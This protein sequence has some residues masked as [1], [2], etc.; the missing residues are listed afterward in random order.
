M[1][2]S[3]I[4]TIIELGQ[5]FSK[6]GNLLYSEEEVDYSPLIR[7]GGEKES[8]EFESWEKIERGV[9]ILGELKAPEISF[10]CEKLEEKESLYS[11]MLSEEH[12]ER[13]VKKIS[14]GKSDIVFSRE[15]VN[16]PE[17][18]LHR[19]YYSRLIE[20][21]IA[22][23]NPFDI[24]KDPKVLK[25]NPEEIKS[26]LEKIDNTIKARMLGPTKEH[27]VSVIAKSMSESIFR[28]VKETYGDT[29]P[30]KG[31]LDEEKKEYEKE[32]RNII[33]KAYKSSLL[34]K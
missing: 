28:G 32:M 12:L 2:S 4:P 5:S 9:E 3:D 21:D 14:P 11:G 7:R 15:I 23:Y 20:L 8:F 31:M 18:N 30:A 6:S 24:I 1:G 19:N 34:H 16:E 25:T 13:D 29:V 10:V 27:L 26:D 33:M 22:G 17:L